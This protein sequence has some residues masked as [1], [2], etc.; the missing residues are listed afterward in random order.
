MSEII[1]K[2]LNILPEFAQLMELQKNIW[3]LNDYGDCLPEHVM[4]A[5]IDIGGLTLG[6]FSGDKIIGFTIA[7]PGFSREH[8]FYHR[9]HILGIEEEYRSQNIAFMLKRE[10]YKYAKELGVSKI[11]WTYDPLL[12]PNANLNISKLGGIVRTY[13]VNEYGENMGGSG[14]VSGVPSDRFLCEW[15]I[16]TERVENRIEGN[17]G[18]PE[19]DLD[20]KGLETVNIVSSEDES[21]TIESIRDFPD[22]EQVIVEIPGNYQ[23]IFD[24]NIE[25]AIDWRMKTRDLFTKC[26]AGGYTVVEFYRKDGRNFYLLQK[27]Y[28]I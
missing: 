28:M 2:K 7:I 25:N 14:L 6:A 24:N 18:A 4:I 5:L 13:K 20:A 19:I 15:F 11:D 21:K 16:N 8:G 9:S 22:S 26:F 12:G 17:S 10:H 27:D 3:I 1:V 23:E